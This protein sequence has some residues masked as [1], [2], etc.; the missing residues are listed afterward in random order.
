MPVAD[1]VTQDVRDEDPVVIDPKQIEAAM[2]AALNT[3][4]AQRHA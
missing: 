2:L 3:F 4:N 1:L